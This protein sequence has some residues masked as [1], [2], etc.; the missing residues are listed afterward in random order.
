[1]KISHNF[2]R[3]Y[4]AVLKEFYNKAPIKLKT[5]LGTLYI[6]GF[7]YEG[8]KQAL[9]FINL[10]YPR[11]FRGYPLSTRDIDNAALVQHIE[12]LIKLAGENGVEFSFVEQEWNLLL[13]RCNG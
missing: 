4:H 12:F 8:F 7:T 1:M 13:R 11:N 5:D 9:K 6:R 3:F 10:D 2:N